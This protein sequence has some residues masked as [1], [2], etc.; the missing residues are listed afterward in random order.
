MANIILL[1]GGKNLLQ[2]FLL[3][4]VHFTNIVCEFNL[5]DTDSS[6]KTNLLQSDC[7]NYYAY[8]E[9]I[10]YQELSDLVEE[11]IPYCVRSTKN[12]NKLNRMTVSPFS[13]RLSFNQMRLSN[14]SIHKLL[15]WS[16]PIE[17]IERY[18]IYLNEPSKTLNEEFYNCTPPWFGL[19]CQY[20]FLSDE[21]LSFNEIVEAN[22][23][24]RTAY[25]KP[26]NTLV[27]VPSY[28]LLE[29]H[30][31]GQRWCLD[32]REIC[33]GKVDC[34]D[35]SLDEK[36]CFDMEVNECN[37]DEYRCH[38][39]LCISEDLWEDGM[40]D[41]DCIDRSDSVIDFSYI[42][43]CHQ[44][45]TFRCEEHSCRARGGSF[46]CG[47][48]QCVHK[49]EKCHNGRHILL[50]NSLTAK[51]NL[52]DQCWMAMICFTGLVDE[53]NESLCKIW[54]MNS[55]VAL[56]FLKQCDSFFQFPTIPVHS[57]H[58]RFFYKDPYLRL[59][60]ST[61]LIPNYICYDQQLC[62]FIIPDLI[63]ENL[64]C[65][66]TYE[67]MVITN[68][69]K[70]LW[71]Q[72]S[73]FIQYDFRFCSFPYVAFHNTRNYSVYLSLYKC[74]HSS[75][76]ISEHRIMDG[77]PDCYEN[78]DETLANSCALNDRYRVTCVDN[79]TCWSP[80]V[81]NIA[82]VLNE[83]DYTTDISFQNVCNG[84]E[85]YFY[86]HNKQEYNDEVGCGN[87]SCNNMYTRCDGYWACDDGQ[88][89][90]N[91]YPKLCPSQTHPCV[92]P[93][94]YTLI[95]VNST[96]IND[97]IDE[98]F[99]GLDEQFYCQHL[100]PLED[101]SYYFKCSTESTC[102]LISQLCD[103][104]D[105]CLWGDDENEDF[106]QNQQL[107]CNQDSEHKLTDVEKVFCRLKE[108]DNNK[109]KYFSIGTSSNYPPLQ[110]ST[111]H[112]F[113]QWSTEPHSLENQ[114]QYQIKNNSWPFYCNRGLAVHTWIENNII[115]YTCICPPSYYGSLCEYQN[116]RISLSLKLSSSDTY[117]TYAIVIM[118]VDDDDERQEV[119]T[120]EQFTYIVKQTC[121][122]KLNRYLLFSARPKNTFKNYSIRIDVF[123]KNTL[124]YTGS[125]HFPIQF[126]FL[127]V[128]RLGLSLNLSNHILQPSF[129]C[130]PP[131]KNGRCI[132]YVNKNRSFCQCFPRWSGIQC[133]IPLHCQ[134]CS[135]DLICIGST[136]N[137]S[138]CVCPIHK[139]GR[140]CLF[141]SI[142][143]ENA[144]QNNGQCIP[145]DLSISGNNY[146]C[147][148]PVQFSGQFCQY[149]KA[150]LDVSLA[151]I[152]VPSY[153]VAHF[154]TLSNKSDPVETIILRKFSLFQLT[155][156][157]HI[158]VPF[159]LV[160]IRADTSYYLAV[161]QQTPQMHISTSISPAQKCQSV[162]Q[163][164]NATVLNMMPYQRILYF[165][166]LCQ[167]NFHLTCFIDKAYLCLCTNDHHANCLPFNSNRQFQCPLNNLCENH[168]QC[169][170]DHPTCPSTKICLCPDCYFGDRC[171]FYSKGM[172]S[173]LDE[174]LG[175]EIKSNTKLSQ[176]SF[177]VKL[178]VTITVVMFI[179]GLVN[180][181]LSI[182]TLARKA[183][184]EVGCGIYLLT[185]CVTSIITM[186]LLSMKFW[187][188]F[189][190][191]QNSHGQQRVL[192]GTCFGT[193]S[194]L[195]IFLY[196]N[197]WL[198]TFVAIERSISVIQGTTFN[199]KYS[200]RIAI[201]VII[202][203]FIIIICLLVPQ[204]I[205]LHIFHDEME[206]RSW[207]V[208]KYMKWIEMYRTV[209]L[210]I[211]HFGPV[212]INTVTMIM[213]VTITAYQKYRAHHN[214]PYSVHVKLQ[215]KKHKHILLSIVAVIL[216]TL[217]YLI[218][219]LILNCK[220]TPVI[221]WLSLIGYYLSF[222]PAT[223]IFV[224]YV[225][226]SP[227]YKT[228]FKALTKHIRRHLSVWK[229]NL[230]RR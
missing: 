158:A 196:Y 216:L 195:R 46:P 60:L 159:Q 110:K 206:E 166:L 219:S 122:V 186:I 86:D 92:S 98:C 161:L 126:L 72:L 11:K 169:L 189:G 162:S 105:D 23:R 49:F 123:E 4:L 208:V 84:I 152:P 220:K 53:V 32:W 51:G 193:E 66:E 9:K 107:R 55:S 176:Q 132:N 224:I 62:N 44:D 45:P 221:F 70:N 73:L 75:N 19:H 96:Y 207:C 36:Y 28:V 160:F 165:H 215:I 82:C 52:N 33:D 133:N 167:A 26:V 121:S 112:Q 2:V 134:T 16:I 128:N 203:S 222:F 18:Q 109:V 127:P 108:L 41:T 111:E 81:K 1:L 3:I 25:S 223:F 24:R 12:S 35:E 65:M 87:W 181:I 97:G 200:Q 139:F 143:P 209:F 198:H 17:V 154:F 85:D 217:P 229:F 42:D 93:I 179:L 78:D 146:T 89:E 218:I 101:A 227:L 174:I 50:A 48:G 199:K 131:C 204:L 170:Q 202:I 40:G 178:S 226:P 191:Y 76:I 21:K 57:N 140:R 15:S 147:L 10:V 34:F 67:L 151:D 149:R 137:Q 156:T 20:S 106:C 39:G 5:Y 56:T 188:L 214:H 120:Y 184:R 210:H 182:L 150:K 230:R 183:S 187:F 135:S 125:W 144:C 163:L 153:I 168:G 31:D 6:F 100:Y 77:I 59:N 172:G 213:I 114:V 173:T 80:L 136:N 63:Y 69:L 185:S 175:Y 148:C 74:R 43:F 192:E 190:S 228:E 129:N 64:T 113:T 155:V 88:D 117:A 201:Y 212:V 8:H 14:I 94:D 79:T 83:F 91:C 37:E 30:R 7:L 13:T 194:L 61:F 141:T 102:L 68:P 164:F 104:K 145:A 58:V 119:N 22:F 211:H 99:G 103:G 157:F 225:L 90:D 142:C 95:C 27:K 29:C 130:F 197:N 54:L 71:S 116:Q 47:D 177:A 115:N 180:S 205:H 171:Q 38:N 138:I 124:T 118:L